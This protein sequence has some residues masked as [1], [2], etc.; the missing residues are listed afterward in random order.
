MYGQVN[1]IVKKHMLSCHILVRLLDGTRPLLPGTSRFLLVVWF[2]ATLTCRFSMVV[3]FP[4]AC[5]AASVWS[6]NNMFLRASRLPGCGVPVS[7]SVCMS[8][9]A[10]NT[11]GFLST[12]I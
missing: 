12:D 7:V 5:A 1:L 9:S 3:G 4:A 10:G 8:S 2:L 11:G 6:L